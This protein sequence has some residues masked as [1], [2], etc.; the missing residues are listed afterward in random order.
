M[1]SIFKQSSQINLPQKFKINKHILALYFKGQG[2]AKVLFYV[3]F[4]TTEPGPP[5]QSITKCL[6]T[7]CNTRLSLLRVTP[8]RRGI[9]ISFRITGMSAKNVALGIMQDG[10][11]AIA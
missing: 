10:Q 5:F 3:F 6:P 9:I 8:V 2:Q 11:K 7:H 1:D 4:R